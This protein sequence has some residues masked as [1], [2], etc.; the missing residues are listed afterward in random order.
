[1]FLPGYSTISPYDNM[2]ESCP[3]TRPWEEV[4]IGGVDED[5]HTIEPDIAPVNHNC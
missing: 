4:V 1:M 3:T 5:G 2:Y